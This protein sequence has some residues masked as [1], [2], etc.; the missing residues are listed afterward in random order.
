M[1]ALSSTI[2]NLRKP[3]TRRLPRVL[4]LAQQEPFLNY[5]WAWVVLQSQQNKPRLPKVF[6]LI[7][8]GLLMAPPRPEGEQ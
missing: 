5:L 3:A 6:L 2:N 4:R 1:L 7:M 8:D